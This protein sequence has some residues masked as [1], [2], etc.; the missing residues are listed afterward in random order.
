MK[1]NPINID[2]L[3][4]VVLR[5]HDVERMVEFY[6]QVLGCRIDRQ[7]TDLGLT[8]LRAGSILI[9]LVSVDGEI[10][11]KGGQGPGHH[12]QNMDHFCL[13]LTSFD[14]ERIQIWLA[15]NACQSES[16]APRYGATVIGDSIYL[17][18]P[19]GNMVELKSP[20]TV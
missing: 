16:A 3:D 4:H 10:G 17:R 1:K 8:Q 5:V 20:H 13:R 19:E 7:Q 9:D 6:C 14:A 2:S 12:G 11:R 18:D 15:E